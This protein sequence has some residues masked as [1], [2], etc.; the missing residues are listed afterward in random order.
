QEMFV[1]DILALAALKTGRAVKLELTREEQF[2]ATSTRHTMRIAVR[3]SADKDGKLTA[4]SLDVLSN[5]GAYGNHAGPVLFHAVGDC[6]GV[7]NCPK[8]KGD[9]IAY[10]PKT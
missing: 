10:S 6:L 8:K 5:T 2:I 9:S 1:E 4:L 3:A 7:C